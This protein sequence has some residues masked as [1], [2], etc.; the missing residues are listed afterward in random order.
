MEIVNTPK[1]RIW[2]VEICL[3]IG[4]HLWWKEEGGL[5]LMV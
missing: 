5:F 1:D 3:K 4:G 2:N